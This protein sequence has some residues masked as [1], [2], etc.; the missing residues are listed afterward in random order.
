MALGCFDCFIYCL[1]YPTSSFTGG[2]FLLHKSEQNMKYRKLGNTTEALSAIGLG[3]KQ[4]YYHYT[5][6]PGVVAV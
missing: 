2:V 6:S 1:I 3:C 4:R 5:I